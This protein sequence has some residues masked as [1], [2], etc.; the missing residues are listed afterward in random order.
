M[1]NYNRS[2]RLWLFCVV[3]FSINSVLGMHNSFNFEAFCEAAQRDNEAALKQSTNALSA[4]ARQRIDSPTT[5]GIQL[6]RLFEI[7]ANP[8]FSSACVAVCNSGTIK[9]ETIK[10]N[11]A[12]SYYRLEILNHL[13]P[14]QA[15]Q[16]IINFLPHESRF[17][18]A[19]YETNPHQFNTMDVTSYKKADLS[20]QS[21]ERIGKILTDP[22]N[23]ELLIIKS[24]APGTDLAKNTET[25]LENISLCLKSELNPANTTLLAGQIKKNTHYLNHVLTLASIDDAKITSIKKAYDQL[26]EHVNSKIQHYGITFTPWE[27][28]LEK[29]DT[30]KNSERNKKPSILTPEETD[31]LNN[32][33][34][35]CAQGSEQHYFFTAIKE[36]IDLMTDNQNNNN[37]STIMS[38]L[39]YRWKEINH[40][41]QAQ[42]APIIQKIIDTDDFKKIVYNNIDTTSSFATQFKDIRTIQL[43]RMRDNILAPKENDSRF[44]H[45]HTPPQRSTPEPTNYQPPVTSQSG[46]ANTRAT[47]GQTGPPVA[48]TRIP[49][50]DFVL[51]TR[52]PPSFTPPVASSTK[53]PRAY[54]LGQTLADWNTYPQ[55]KDQAYRQ[56]LTTNLTKALDELNTLLKTTSPDTAQVDK[57]LDHVKENTLGATALEDFKLAHLKNKYPSTFTDINFVSAPAGLCEITLE[58][59]TKVLLNVDS[60]TEFGKDLGHIHAFLSQGCSVAKVKSLTDAIIKCDAQLTK[61]LDLSTENTT[62]FKNLFTTAEC[63]QACK[64]MQNGSDWQGK[65]Q[66]I[67]AIQSLEKRFTLL[68]S[69]N[70]SD[71]KVNLLNPDQK[72]STLTSTSFFTKGFLFKATIVCG[73]SFAALLAL[74][75]FDLIKIF[76]KD[77]IF[78]RA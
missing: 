25:Y 10:K 19:I 24:I 49:P 73:I 12:D 28:L 69:D 59:A 72:R 40:E 1:M 76:N 11:V 45:I 30:K 26:Q 14:C 22:L 43:K 8:E 51:Q 64:F 66:F 18:L 70:N 67:K 58:A 62:A 75:K 52:T 32:T 65:N 29:K 78:S 2:T 38:D 7:F 68:G 42:T 21:I 34:E 13:T 77:K 44:H 56:K 35:Q 60:P 16:A 39:A 31:F 47:A 33:L 37:I 4:L 50:M 53:E 3:L 9:D 6:A 57:A 48:P 20:L 46:Q 15:P 23:D 27:N 5:A 71:E 55:L 17:L 41:L 36:L 74:W 61:N 63:Y 54:T